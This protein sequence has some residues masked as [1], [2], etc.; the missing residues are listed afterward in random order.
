MGFMLF[1]TEQ[2]M[3]PT[4]AG[5]ASA[6]ETMDWVRM[7]ERVLKLALPT[8][9][10]WLCMFWMLF[11]LGLNIIAEVTRFGDREFYKVRKEAWEGF[12]LTEVSL[13]HCER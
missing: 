11:H 3:R 4:I 7:S 2:Y 13:W 5:S 12:R 1:I 8:M 10:L 6:L 9:Y